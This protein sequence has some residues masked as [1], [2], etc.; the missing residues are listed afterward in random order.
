MVDR[1]VSHLG[2]EH[3]HHAD[4]VGDVLSAVHLGGRV[5]DHQARGVQLDGGVGDP[6]LDGLAVREPNSESRAVVGVIG[7]HL[8]RAG[9]DAD[10]GGAHLEPPR[11]Q[12]KLHRL[13]ALTH[14]AQQRVVRQVAVLEE[15]L[16]GEAAADHRDFTLKDVSRRPP[17]HDERGDPR[18]PLALA[19]PSHHDG[20]VR[21]LGRADPNLPAVQHPAVSG[22]LGLGAHAGRIAA[23][24]R[25]GDGDGRGHAAFDVGLQIFLF[26]LVRTDCLQHA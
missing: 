13:V 16:V 7:Q 17:F 9:G 20:E 12:P 5:L 24:L 25:F 10:G 1:G 11:T 21:S 15:D 14:F 26:L 4:L 23:S 2:S 3:L 19:H 6:P 18:P 22:L 8:D